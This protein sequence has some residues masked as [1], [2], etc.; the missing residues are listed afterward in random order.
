MPNAHRMDKIQIV[1]LKRKLELLKKDV[2]SIE[3]TIDELEHFA[4]DGCVE[5]GGL[6]SL[7]QAIKKTDTVARQFRL[8]LRKYEGFA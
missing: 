2:I 3:A 6:F 7:R 1:Q 8:S 4:V 5:T